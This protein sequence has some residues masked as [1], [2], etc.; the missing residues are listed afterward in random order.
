MSAPKV[1]MCKLCQARH[2]FGTPHVFGHVT[3]VVGPYTKE[4]TYPQSVRVMEDVMLPS[5]A[6]LA[7]TEQPPAKLTFG[8]TSA[9]P[10]LPDEFG[11]PDVWQALMAL[12]ARIGALE[13][14]LQP[15]TERNTGNA[16]LVTGINP[17]PSA[18][19]NGNGGNESSNAVTDGP[20]TVTPSSNAVTRNAD[21]QKA[22][23]ERKKA[24]A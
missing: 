15:V 8:V 16:G 18:G 14:Y 6:T 21:K 2:G 12:E 22:Y 17:L 4:V 11:S 1:Q 9:K 24:Q 10:I 20:V 5:S 13:R 3:P 7:V 23:R 19:N